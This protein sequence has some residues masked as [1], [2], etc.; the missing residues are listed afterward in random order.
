MPFSFVVFFEISFGKPFEVIESNIAPHPPKRKKRKK[1]MFHL[2]RSTLWIIFTRISPTFSVVGVNRIDRQT[3]SLGTSEAR[4]LLDSHLSVLRHRTRSRI[5]YFGSEHTRQ[6]SAPGFS[7][8]DLTDICF[9]GCK[10]LFLFSLL[11]FL[12]IYILDLY[13]IDSFRCDFQ[14]FMFI[15]FHYSLLRR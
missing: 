12:F 11:L 14:M 8:D 2:T 1:V 4:N 15:C 7:F 6:T 10:C 3:D 9:M 5:N 13:A